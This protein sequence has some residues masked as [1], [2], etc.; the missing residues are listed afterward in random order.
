MLLFVNFNR[1]PAE[2]DRFSVNGN[3][4]A[5][6]DYALP[7]HAGLVYVLLDRA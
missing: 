5:H 6:P 4:Q 3:R 7:W 2:D 1:P